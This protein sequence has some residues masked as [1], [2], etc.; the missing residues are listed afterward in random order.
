MAPIKSNRLKE[1]REAV[2]LTQEEVSKIVG[3]DSSLVAHHE[4]STRAITDD[5]LSA[6]ARLYKVPTHQLFMEPSAPAAE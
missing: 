5:D 2:R 4:N 6:Y 1:L 3:K